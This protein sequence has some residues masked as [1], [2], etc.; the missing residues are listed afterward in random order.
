MAT[1]RVESSCQQPDGVSPPVVSG[2]RGENRVPL[3][4]SGE[5]CGVRRRS[6][7]CRGLPPP[8]RRLPTLL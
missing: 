4:S 8:D 5:R 1:G 2:L 7:P 3:G 6:W